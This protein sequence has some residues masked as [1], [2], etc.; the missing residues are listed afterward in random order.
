[1]TQMI[2]GLAVMVPALLMA[3]PLQAEEP[4]AGRYRMERGERGLIRLDTATGE[5]SLCRENGETVTCRMAADERAA[6]EREL[7]DLTRRVEALEKAER[8]APPPRPSANLPT[9]AEID[10]S[11]GIME[12]WMRSFFDMVQS[13]ENRSGENRSG[14]PSG[15]GSGEESG[16]LPDKT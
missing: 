11:I 12:R 8:Q 13:F 5:V 16:S 3:L 1:M 6:F 14:A 7:D 2:R 9:D 15:S 4:A 10:R